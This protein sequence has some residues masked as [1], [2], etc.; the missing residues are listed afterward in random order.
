MLIG[1]ASDNDVAWL[2]STGKPVI[3]VS[4]TASAPVPFTEV[5][6]PTGTTQRFTITEPG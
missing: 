3:I 1:G 5:T 4:Q 6:D 2:H